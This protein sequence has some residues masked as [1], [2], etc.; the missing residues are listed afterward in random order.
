MANGSLRGS[1]LLTSA[2]AWHALSSYVIFITAARMLGEARFGD[3]GLVAWTMTTLETLVVAGIPRA[4]SYFVARDPGGAA[5]VTRSGM[6]LTFTVAAVLTVLLLAASPLIVSL[7]RDPVMLNALR[8]SA[9]DFV[10]F[11]GFAVLVQAV[12]GLHLFRRQAGIWIFYSTVKVVAVVA[13]LRFGGSIEWGIAGYV[14]ASAVASGVAFAAAIGPIGRGRAGNS[15]GAT[16]MVR[17]G[18]P[19]GLQAV[20]FMTLLNADLWAAKW[21][22][23][24]RR[25]AGGYVAAG[26][27]ARVLF[28][29]FVAFGEAIFPAVARALKDGRREEAMDR[30][31]EVTGLLVCLLVPATGLATGTAGPVLAAVYGASESGFRVAAPFLALLAPAAA[32]LTLVAVL[33]AVLSAAGH[34]GRMARLLG[35][36]VAL[37]VGCVFAGAHLWGPTGAAAGALGVALAGMLVTIAWSRRIFGAAPVPARAAISALAVAAAIHI[38]AR[39][40][41]PEGL[42]IFVYGAALL[43]VGL[44]ILGFVN[45][46]LRPS[47]SSVPSPHRRR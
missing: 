30:V 33:A 7:W 28:F 32:A 45:P 17:F 10:A 39:A 36:L 20:G 42:W 2:Q 34:A 27:L 12:N 46:R 22:T 31:R 47:G 13:M 26:T 24:D 3:F 14:V 25:V 38:T 4:V 40:W 6:K 1:L 29:V 44:A 15:P 37:D 9:F 43:G 11:T 19:V 18:L 8:I 35:G 5:A 41:S 23:A 16:A 21:A